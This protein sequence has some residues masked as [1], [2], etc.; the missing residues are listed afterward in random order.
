[1]SAHLHSVGLLTA[2]LPAALAFYRLLGLA[3]PDGEGRW[4]PPERSAPS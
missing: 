4:P 1:M 3:V 2:D